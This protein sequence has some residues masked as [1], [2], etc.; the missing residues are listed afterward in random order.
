V[1]LRSLARTRRGLQY[2]VAGPNPRYRKFVEQM[3][4][5]AEAESVRARALQW[6]NA[7]DEE[8]SRALIELLR[9]FERS[10]AS[11]VPPYQKPPLRPLPEPLRPRQDQEIA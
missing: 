7:T 11:Q 6:R 10:A 9:A 5:A 1:R 3:K 2:P 4:R 8:C